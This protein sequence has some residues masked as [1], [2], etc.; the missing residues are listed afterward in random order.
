MSDFSDC[1]AC[2]G[3]NAEETPACGTCGGRGMRPVTAENFELT[4]SAQEWA[5]ERVSELFHAWC[6]A[7]GMHPAY[8]VKDWSLGNEFISIEQDTSCMGCA[9]SEQHKLP[10]AWLFAGPEERQAMMAQEVERLAEKAAG[11]RESERLREIGNLQRRLARL[12]AQP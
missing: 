4:I 12:T 9:D 7:S 8:G 1:P 11:K 6:K 5:D 10:A 2:G 3:F